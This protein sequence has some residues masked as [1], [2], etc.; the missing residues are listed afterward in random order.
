MQLRSLSSRSEFWLVT[1]L[2]TLGYLGHFAPYLS[3]FSDSLF[4]FSVPDDVRTVSWNTW[5]FSEQIKSGSNP[6]A[7]G[8][9]AYPSGSSLLMHAYTPYFGILNLIFN[10]VALSIN[11]GL[12]IQMIIMGLGFYYLSKRWLTSPITCFAVAFIAVFNTYYLEKIGVHL[13]LVLMASVPWLIYLCLASVD[14]G[15]AGLNVVSKKK[16]LLFLALLFAQFLFDYYALF[17]SLSFLLIHVS[18][19]LL[20]PKIRHIKSWYLG[21]AGLGIIGVGHVI[22]RLLRINGWDKK[23]AFWASPDV[24]SLI[25]PSSNNHFLGNFHVQN[26][27]HTLNDHKMFLGYTLLLLLVVAVGFLGVRKL[28]NVKVQSQPGLGFVA[29]AIVIFLFV[30]F[31]VFHVSGK[32]F[33]YSFTGIVHFIPFVQ[34]VRASDRFV[35][36]L[37]WLVPLLIFMVFEGSKNAK[38]LIPVLGVLI[39]FSSF[40]EHKM[41]KMQKDDTRVEYGL[42]IPDHIQS[43]LLLPYGLRD[44]YQHFGDFDSEQ[45]R[46]QQHHPIALPSAYLSRLSDTIWSSARSNDFLQALVD[47]QETSGVDAKKS[48]D[49]RSELDELQLDALVVSRIYLDSMPHLK[50]SLFQWSNPSMKERFIRFEHETDAKQDWLILY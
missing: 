28:K 17:F 3:S 40:S 41:I 4:F 45:L 33:L 38:T 36:L 14:Y 13:N 18:Y 42:E 46:L 23:G 6:F 39:I 47:L 10:N 49:L 31:P 26:L 29:L 7:T 15:Q 30:C 9:L 48:F 35:A 11:I 24:R 20:W 50:R 19:R 5:H 37:F 2:L 8:L 27:P 32:K 1:L 21:L 16:L 44:G 25:N 43:A 34:N 12:G 22:V